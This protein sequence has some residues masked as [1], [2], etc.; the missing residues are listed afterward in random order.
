MTARN[1][2]RFTRTI[3]VMKNLLKFL[4]TLFA[5]ILL[6]GCVSDDQRSVCA[7]PLRTQFDLIYIENNPRADNPQVRN[8]IVGHLLEMGYLVQ[9][10]EQGVSPE[11]SV[12]LT[13]D[14][15]TVGDTIKTLGKISIEVR[16]GQ[17]LLGYAHDDARGFKRLGNTRERLDPLLDGIFEYVMPKKPTPQD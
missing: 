17:R 6:T 9:I 16:K 1:K 3:E 10:C 4:P 12:V 7:I 2:T 15:K 13:Y 14:C 8:E 5:A 11:N